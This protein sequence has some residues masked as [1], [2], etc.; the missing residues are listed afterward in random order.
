MSKLTLTIRSHHTAG[1][2]I[3][4]WR[5]RKEMSQSGLS[6]RLSRTAGLK[7]GNTTIPKIE[8]GT[9]GLSVTEAA[10]FSEALGIPWDEFK[11][12]HRPEQP[13]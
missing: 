8:N 3:K 1:Q 2:V 4:T 13:A 11:I 7:I 5:L 6:E 10:A 9:R 12:H